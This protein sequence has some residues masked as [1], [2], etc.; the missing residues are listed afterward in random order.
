[1]IAAQVPDRANEQP[2]PKRGRCLVVAGLPYVAM[3]VVALSLGGCSTARS[4]TGYV[5]RQVNTAI[6]QV[7]TAIVYVWSGSSSKPA[8]APASSPPS[9]TTAI[10]VPTSTPVATTTPVATPTAPPPA[11]AE[12]PKPPQPSAP[13]PPVVG[14]NPPPRPADPKAP[15]PPVVEPAAPVAVVVTT[16][17]P[18]GVLASDPRLGVRATR[19]PA[20]TTLRLPVSLQ[21]SSG[22]T[23]PV[24]T[25]TAALDFAPGA[26]QVETIVQ[27]APIEEAVQQIVVAVSSADP[28][29]SVTGAPATVPVVSRERVAFE[30]FSAERDSTAQ[31]GKATEYLRD[32]PNGPHRGDALEAAARV[33]GTGSDDRCLSPELGALATLS[34]P[35]TLSHDSAQRVLSARREYD[36]LSAKLV[37]LDDRDLYA[38]VQRFLQN[39]ERT[40][41]GKAAAPWKGQAYWQGLGSGWKAQRALAEYYVRVARK[42]DALTV[43][44]GPSLQRDIR[45][46]VLKGRVHEDLGNTAQASAAYREALNLPPDPAASQDIN[47]ARINQAS[48]EM[49]SDRNAALNRLYAAVKSDPACALCWYDLGQAL[50]LHNRDPE[51]KAA[52]A[53][54]REAARANPVKWQE[55]L[56]S[57]DNMDKKQP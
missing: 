1:M 38:S 47:D 19:H 6:D 41:C 40:G 16:T 36:I 52:L 25:E 43:L 14:G 44:D 31:L 53:K 54:A 26:T 21:I 12:P 7:N 50:K 45:S 32:F 13:P 3:A 23:F 2:C 5:M 17:D 29:Q 20:T 28:N 27:L 8:P 49:A 11:A 37:A 51:A 33:I 30:A 56:H 18:R 15:P 4:A 42:T 22:S 48:I 10:A 57:L 35:V 46:L 34:P 55:V 24:R 9:T 39:Y